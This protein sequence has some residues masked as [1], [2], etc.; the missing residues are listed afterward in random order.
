MLSIIRARAFFCALGRRQPRVDEAWAVDGVS[1][2]QTPCRAANLPSALVVLC[3]SDQ[4]RLSQVE[5]VSALAL[6]GYTAGAGSVLTK[7]RLENCRSPQHTGLSMA[8]AF[9]SAPLRGLS[10]LVSHAAFRG[11]RSPVQCSA[12]RAASTDV[13]RVGVGVVCLRPSRTLDG[14]TEVMTTA[15][16][17]RQL[18]G[19]ESP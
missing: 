6:V 16:W 15:V 2:E 14:S 19:L 8:G 3:C 1:D 18:R 9:L 7:R 5:P 11:V 12:T 13:P 10:A 17:S 4:A